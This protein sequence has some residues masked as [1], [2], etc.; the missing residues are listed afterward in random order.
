MS[1]INPMWL[2]PVRVVYRLSDV[3]EA[4]NS[5]LEDN[6]KLL[7]KHEGSP[8]LSGFYRSKIDVQERSLN[9][10]KDWIGQSVEYLETE[11]VLYESSP[12]FYNHENNLCRQIEY[13]KLKPVGL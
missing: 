4:L 1:D 9:F 11:A 13:G 3:F 5:N 7:L 8:L 12:L 2:Q 6:Q 10:L